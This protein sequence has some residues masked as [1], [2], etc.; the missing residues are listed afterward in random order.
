M[1]VFGTIGYR[2]SHILTSLACLLFRRGERVLYFLRYIIVTYPPS[3]RPTLSLSCPS[4]PYHAPAFVIVGAPP[5]VGV[6]SVVSSPP[7]C[8]R[9]TRPPSSL[10]LAFYIFIAAVLC[11]VYS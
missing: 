2:T 7:A 5:V 9:V 8:A 4:R 3:S 11:L 1:S 6:P 10:S